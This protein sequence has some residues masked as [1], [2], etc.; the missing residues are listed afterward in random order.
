MQA[1]RLDQEMLFH[2]CQAGR[3]GLGHYGSVSHHVLRDHSLSY[4]SLLA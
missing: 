2:P 1:R 3:V 4:A